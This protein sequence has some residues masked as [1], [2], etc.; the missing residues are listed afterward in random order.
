M[1]LAEIVRV[2][3][4]ICWQ[5]GLQCQI[6]LWSACCMLSDT[7]A[8]HQAPRLQLKNSEPGAVGCMG[9]GKSLS[10]PGMQANQRSFCPIV[11]NPHTSTR[12]GCLLPIAVLPDRRGSHFSI[13]G[14][15]SASS[16]TISE[17]GCSNTAHHAR[18]LAHSAQH[19]STLARTDALVPPR[20]RSLP[21]T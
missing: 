11:G 13:G 4:E 21:D 17:P 6:D 5:D 20:P 2:H 18:V 8:C 15:V 12:P 19:H 14:P 1:L 10:Y 7:P 3:P 16:R 9:L